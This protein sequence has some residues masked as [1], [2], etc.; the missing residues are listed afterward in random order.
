MQPK[1]LNKLPGEPSSSWNSWR[2]A[3]TQLTKNK[4]SGTLISNELTD[5]QK[6]ILGEIWENNLKVES[7]R[8][9]QWIAWDFVTLKLW[10]NWKSYKMFFPEGATETF[11]DL[12]IANNKKEFEEIEN[13]FKENW[14]N[15]PLKTSLLFLLGNIIK[16]PF[17]KPQDSKSKIFNVDDSFSFNWYPTPNDN[18]KLLLIK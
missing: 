1:E 5:E 7:D 13:Y 8:E 9:F 3:V 2:K 15:K 10:D 14:V 12:F 17:W 18:A 11:L 16:S 6:R 4:V